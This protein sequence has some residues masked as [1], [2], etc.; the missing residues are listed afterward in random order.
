[1]KTWS[2]NP[3]HEGFCV[4]FFL[5]TMILVYLIDET[6]KSLTTFL[7]LLSK[8]PFAEIVSSSFVIYEFMGARKREHYLRIAADNFTEKKSGNLNF[9]SL[10]H[11]IDYFKNPN[12][13][14][15]NEVGKIQNSVM[16]EIEKLK[17][18]FNIDPDYSSFHEDQLKSARDICLSTKIANQ[19]SLVI[20]S[21]VLPQPN[22][23]C[24]AVFLTND[25]NLCAWYNK[26][27]ASAVLENLNICSPRLIKID[28]IPGI[29]ILGEDILT[30][31]KIE[32]N[33]TPLLFSLICQNR[34][35][36]YIGKTFT[37]HGEGFPNN[38]I[39]FK[40][41]ENRPLVNGEDGKYVTIL[42]KDLDFIYTSKKP[43]RFWNNGAEIIDGFTALP[44]NN[45]ISYCIVDVDENGNE[46]PV[47]LEIIELLRIDGNHVFIHPDS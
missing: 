29:R 25:T 9:A 4:K 43:V 16:E 35:K 5:D 31:D 36:E 22:K 46:I 26:G 45:N 2:D 1:M 19:D 24:E 21:S 17:T 10:F 8:N 20:V 44:D 3:I 18:D 15:E 41:R 11:N 30:S 7:N 40:L 27:N 13:K 28:A 6:H 38:C 33:I 14:F 12:A 39:C 34:E 42:S 23:S 37:H 47:L 32:E